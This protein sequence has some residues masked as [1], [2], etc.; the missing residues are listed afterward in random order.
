MERLYFIVNILAGG[1]RCETCFKQV[2]AELAAR[3]I[4]Y[5]CA[6][7][8]YRRHAV[9]LAKAA[10][11]SGERTIVAVGGDGTVNEVASVLAGTEAVMGVMPFGTGN[12][13][14]R[15]LNFPTE[16][17]AALEAILLGNVRRMDA[18]DAN[19]HFFIN[20]AGFGFDVDVLV[21]TEKH[22]RRYRGMLPYL[23]G[24]LDALVHLKALPVRIHL[25]DGSVKEMDALLIAVGNGAYFGGGMKVAPEADPFDGAFDVCVVHKV[26][27]LKFIKLLPRFI[28]GTHIGLS[29]IEYFRASELYVEGP[30]YSVIDVDG[31]LYSHAPARFTLKKQAVNM[32]VGAK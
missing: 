10:Y 17:K 5:E 12:D 8:Q 21:C 15:V 32:I 16:P 26:S 28:K 27:R 3:N 11:E 6:V 25:E 7:T 1:G 31:E 30:Q 9:E 29:V 20:V 24:I 22:K 2:E 13:L 18:A 14:A 23:L 4:P 19:G